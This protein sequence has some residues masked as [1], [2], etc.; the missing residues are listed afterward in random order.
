[1]TGS[2]RVCNLSSD[3]DSAFPLQ[4]QPH[5]SLHPAQVPSVSLYRPSP[6]SVCTLHKSP[7]FP[8]TDPAPLQSA[9]CTSPLCFP[10]QTQP[11]FSL[12]PAQ[13]PSVSLYRR[14]PTSVCTLHKSPLFPFTDPAPLQSAPCTSPLCFPLQTQPHFSLHPAQVPSVSLYRPSPTSVCTLHTSPLFPFTDP[15]PL[16]SA[17]CTSP[18]CFPLQTQP[19]FSLHPAQVPSV[20]LYRPSPTSVCTL[21]KSPLFP[22]TDPAPL[23]S[24]PCTSPLCFPLQTQPHFSLHPAQVP[25]VS[26][27]RPSPT[28]VCTLHKSPLFPFTDP[29]PLQS[30]PC[31]SPLCFP[32]QTPPHFSLHPAQVPSVSLYRPSPT[33][34]CTLHKSPLFPFTDPAPLQSAPCTRPLCFPLQTQPHFSLHP[35]Q[36][37]SVSLYRPSPT[38][39]CTL[40]K[41]PLFPFTDPAPLQ[42]APCTS[43]LCF[44]LQ[45]QPHFS[46]H[47]A[48]VPSVSLYRPSPTSVCT[49]HKSPLF[50]FTDPAPLQSAPCTSPLCFPLQTQPHFSLHPA[51][52]PSVS[53][54]RPSPTSVCTLHKSPLFPFTDPAPLQSAPC[55]SPLCFPLQTQPHFSLH[56]AQVP[57]VSL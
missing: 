3:K 10:L 41:S 33:S 39:V 5:F 9:P 12:H 24:A 19:H 2:A 25:S 43:P 53:L 27:Y 29:A 57:S 8:F 14:C 6:T 38:S 4:T 48:Q 42:S 11:H 7:L 46:L 18:L 22:F 26:L 47:P 56:P 52:V 16:Q 17:P 28:S 51:Q 21:H 34:V 40:H 44:P 15:A 45:T 23:Q 49:L 55:T 1:M 36:V 35:A 54:Y 37:P 20:S 13:V 31:T 50:P 30:A 32:L